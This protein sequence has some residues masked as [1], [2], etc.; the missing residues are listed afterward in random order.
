MKKGFS[1]VEILV[2]IVIASTALTAI[3]ALSVQNISAAQVT[4][5]KFTAANLAQ[6]GIEIVINLRSNNWLS[7]PQTTDA[8]VDALT[9]ELLHWR[10]G[11]VDGTFIA[12][13]NSTSLTAPNLNEERLVR[14]NNGTYCHAVLAG[15]LNG[16][17]VPFSRVISVS[18]IN[19]H[20]IKVTSTVTW[21]YH[22]QP[23]SVTVEDRLYNWR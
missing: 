16:S 19:S 11:I 9:G 4:R 15:C 6:E 14:L 13:F 8:N 12:Q 21:T 22:N 3:I 23:Y 10:D 20:H 7:Y 17:A 18:T 1:F 2:A 5:D